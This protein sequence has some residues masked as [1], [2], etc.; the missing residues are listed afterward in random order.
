MCVNLCRFVSKRKAAYVCVTLLRLIS[1]R[2]ECLAKNQF[3]LN[4]I[5]E[6]YIIFVADIYRD[7]N[8]EYVFIFFIVKYLFLTNRSM[9]LRLQFSI[10]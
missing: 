4:G 8:V 6:E 5:K 7:N 9:L 10:I 1:E 3:V 2:S